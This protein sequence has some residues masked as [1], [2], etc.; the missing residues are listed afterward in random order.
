MK[1]LL[2]N[3]RWVL[4]T[5]F[6]FLVIGLVLV[7]LYGKADIHIFINRNSNQTTDFIFK[8]FT[9]L[10]D[11]IFAVIIAL[12]LL[13]IRFRESIM[14]LLGFVLSGLFTQL[15]KRFVF[16]GMPRPIAYFEGIYDLHLV[17]GISIAKYNTFPSG[18]TA[19]AFALAFCLI[20]TTSNR[21]L[22]FLY[23][24]IAILVGYSRMH[25]SVHFLP[26]VLAGSA[27]GVI[28]AIIAVSLINRWKANWL[29]RSLQKQIVSKR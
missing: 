12:A 17:E 25:L 7:Q 20:F 16:S 13:F 11:G 27:L 6:L 2:R 15:L 19:T 18:H 4:A 24:I 8:Y 28:S 9:H 21:P 1:S 14:Q 22:Q 10:G 3:N 23:L 5:Y 26:D 29:D